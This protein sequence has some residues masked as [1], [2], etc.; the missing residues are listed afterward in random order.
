MSAP[1]FLTF[2]PYGYDRLGYK[3]IKYEEGG[4]GGVH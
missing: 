2:Y 3:M 4:K 1:P